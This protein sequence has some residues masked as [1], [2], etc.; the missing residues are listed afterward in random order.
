MR[1]CRFID[2]DGIR[3]G[4]VEVIDGQD[5]ITARLRGP[6]LQLNE[7]GTPET[8]LLPDFS[9]PESLE[10]PIPL[11]SAMLLVPLPNISKIVCVGRN[12]KDHVK[13]FNRELPPEPILFLKPPTSLLHPGGKIIRPKL[14]QRLDHEAE[15]GIVIGR[16]CHKLLP[17]EDIRQYILGYTCVNDVTARDL[18][19]KDGQWT[20]GKGFDTF[21]PVGP[22]IATDLDASQLRVQARVNGKLRQDANT[23]DLIFGLDVVMRHSSEAMTLLPGDIVATGTPSGVGN[24]EAGD[25]VEVTVEGIGTLRNV[26]VAE[27]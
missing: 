21:C 23:R 3:Y 6:H 26:V 17:D 16:T 10:K 18:Q 12:Y 4:L 25:T 8:I 1:F 2:R 22:V 9:R 13:E 7:S 11:E 20:R 14:T 27:S 24:M 19:Q 5:A 15:L